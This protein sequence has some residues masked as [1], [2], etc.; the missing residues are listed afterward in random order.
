MTGAQ[1][2]KLAAFHGVAL[3]ELAQQRASLED[4]F[5]DLTSDSVEYHGASA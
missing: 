1:I 4:V 2:G 5:M 3:S